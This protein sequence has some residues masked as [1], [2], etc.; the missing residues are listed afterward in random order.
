[1]PEGTSFGKYL[2]FP[3]FLSR[4]RKTDFQFLLDNFKTR[5]AGWKISFLTMAGRTSLIKSTLNSLPNHVT[6]YISIP[7]SIIHKMEQYQCNSLWGTT[8]TRKI[9]HLL[10]W[11]IV[12]APKDSGGLGIQQLRHKNN[13]ILASLGE[14]YILHKPFGIPHSFINIYM[15]LQL[16]IIHTFGVMFLKDGHIAKLVFNEKLEEVSISTSGMILG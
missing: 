6:Q 10:N 5:L 7:H 15:R 16:I 12:T 4:Q 13:A 8:Q 9:L 14:F 1:M 3:I 11:Q 2:E